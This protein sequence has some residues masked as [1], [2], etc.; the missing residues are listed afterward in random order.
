LFK[1][2]TRSRFKRRA[3]DGLSGEF[4]AVRRGGGEPRI[5]LRHDAFQFSPHYYSILPRSIF[6][7]W[8][9]NKSE[10]SSWGV[11]RKNQ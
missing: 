3:A 10:Y 1:H 8:G 9:L 7:E 11:P 6:A 2:K 4:A 5:L